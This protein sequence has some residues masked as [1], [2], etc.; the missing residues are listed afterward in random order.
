[1]KSGPQGRLSQIV[2]RGLCGSVAYP[3]RAT[4]VTQQRFSPGSSRASSRLKATRSTNPVSS[5]WFSPTDQLSVTDS[6]GVE[7]TVSHDDAAID[8]AR[9][10]GISVRLRT[11]KSS[12]A[13][14]RTGDQLS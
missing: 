2:E 9:L 5:E 3:G 10:V 7:R 8:A 13:S 14:A 12:A 1:M 11:A 6:E 4:N